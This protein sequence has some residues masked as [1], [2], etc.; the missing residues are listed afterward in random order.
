MP[1]RAAD[2]PKPLL[3]D[4]GVRSIALLLPISGRFE[5]PASALRDGFFAAHLASRYPRPLIHVYDSGE[6][7]ES[8]LTAYDTAIERSPD[9]VVGPLLREQLDALAN[10][11]QFVRPVL[12]LNYLDDAIAPPPLLYQFG[13]SPEDEA[14]EAAASAIDSNLRSAVILAEESDWGTRTASSFRDHF[15]AL[16]GTVLRT[17]RFSAV[18]DDSSETIRGLLDRRTINGS[19]DEDI[20]TVFIATG[21]A[22]ARLI[23]PELRFYWHR[24]NDLVVYGVAASYD[25]SL[26][27]TDREGLRFCGMPVVLASASIGADPYGTS[28]AQSVGRT[29]LQS[30]GFDAYRIARAIRLKEFVVGTTIDGRT[31]ALLVQDDGRILR[32]LSC[33]EVSDGHLQALDNSATATAYRQPTLTALEDR[34]DDGARQTR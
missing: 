22:Q 7:G 12:S 6:T 24:P 1:V 2:P 31:G 13:L 18:G 25:R 19:A 30:L 34:L 15:E 32:R 16:G 27:A 11:R 23:I 17:R 3:T 8:A 9:I 20:E 26:S 33:S 5:N 29:R 28:S 4:S 10:Q 14:R 21:A